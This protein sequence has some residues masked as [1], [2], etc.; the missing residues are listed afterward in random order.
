MLTH[1]VNN[2]ISERSRHLTEKQV[3]KIFRYPHMADPMNQYVAD[4]IF[5]EAS[6][7]EIV[8]FLKK[9]NIPFDKARRF[10]SIYKESGQ[11]V[12]KEKYEWFFG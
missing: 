4:V 2:S 3:A 9:N 6:L 5:Q 1:T 8:R 11:G 12:Y 7:E 10:F